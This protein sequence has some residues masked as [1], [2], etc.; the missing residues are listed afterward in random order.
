MVEE[1]MEGEESGV[2]EMEEAVENDVVEKERMVEVVEM[3]EEGV[4]V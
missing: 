4:M 3:M 1:V 2:T